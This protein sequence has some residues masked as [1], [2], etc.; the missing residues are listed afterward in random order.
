VKIPLPKRE[1]KEGF[2]R[3]FK[4]AEVEEFYVE[5]RRGIFEEWQMLSVGGF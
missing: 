5:T 4:V 1:E 3:D 2:N